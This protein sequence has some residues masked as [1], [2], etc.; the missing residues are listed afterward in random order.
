MIAV[1][2]QDEYGINAFDKQKKAAESPVAKVPAVDC[3][4][5]CLCGAVNNFV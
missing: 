3:F 5:K 1:F 4:Y 2:L